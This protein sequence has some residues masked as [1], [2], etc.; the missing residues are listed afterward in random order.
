M[1]LTFFTLAMLLFIGVV[2][3]AVGAL[4]GI[5]GG[6][7][8][9]PAL[10][11]G[12]GVSFRSAVAVSLAAVIANSAMGS[13][14]YLRQGLTHK[15]LA[16]SLEIATTIGGIGGSLLT[17]LIPRAALEGVFGAAQFL[18]AELTRR[19]RRL[20]NRPVPS[21]PAPQRVP[22]GGSPLDAPSLDAPHLDAAPPDALASYGLRA[23]EGGSALDGLVADE[24]DGT[25]LA[26]RARRPLV[27]SGASLVAGLLSGM[28]GIGGGFLKVPAMTLGMGV[29]VRVATAT[30]Q[31]MIGITAVA[32][33]VVYYAS[34][35]VQ[36]LLVAPIV[37]GITAGSLFGSR[38]AGRVSVAVIEAVYSTVVL[39][40]GLSFVL[41]AFGVIHV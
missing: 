36:P 20:Q 11:L 10:V 31:F 3:G 25:T 23:C 5:G 2:A 24:T 12:Y 41:A 6:A 30:S 13:A 19:R 14:T 26:Y 7:I 34:G 22:A 29:P 18:S 9:V 21:A 40:S 37:L 27:G 15:R 28:L 1:T 16:F 38:L 39:A 35:V 8:V 33:F 17:A 4:S 32:S